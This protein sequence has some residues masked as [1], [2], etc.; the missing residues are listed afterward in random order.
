[1]MIKLLDL[2]LIKEDE[3]MLRKNFNEQQSDALV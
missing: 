1:M 3:M 2:H